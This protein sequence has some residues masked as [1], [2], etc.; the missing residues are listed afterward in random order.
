MCAS[1]AGLS[2]FC[3]VLLFMRGEGLAVV[4]W[5]VVGWERGCVGGGGRAS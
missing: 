1:T 4:G 5:G 3:I 2:S